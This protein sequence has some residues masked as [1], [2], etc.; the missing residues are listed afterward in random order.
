MFEIL[1]DKIRLWDDGISD[2]N[3]EKCSNA[4]KMVKDAIA[5]SDFDYKD[6]IDIQ[7]Q[8]SFANNTNISKESDID[9][10]VV[11]SN[12]FF[13]NTVP[14]K[15]S[16][17]YGYINSEYTFNSF[18]TDIFRILNEKFKSTAPVIGKKSIKISENSYHSKIDVVPFFIYR[19]YDLFGNYSEGVALL[20]ENGKVV[21]NYPKQH[22]ENN[23]K[24]NIDTLYYYKKMVRCIKHIKEEMK[25]NDI[26]V[27]NIK[28]FV[29]E[30]LVYNVPNTLF[31]IDC[32]KMTNPSAPKA[33]LLISVVNK[34]I[35]LIK[36]NCNNLVE[37][38]NIKKLFDNTANRNSNDYLNFFN[39]LLEFI[40]NE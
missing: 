5:D 16:A 28:S 3:K 14:P 8:G 15:T 17:D 18:K 40:K 1:E 11:L 21:A 7:L 30:S 23:T 32:Y 20:D 24:K 26:D 35:Y 10:G 38:N 13:V 25:E 19:N 9:I 39:T 33:A 37:A 34:I 4:L 22:I 2:T 31:N 29:L 36:Y 6:N 27:S 12:R